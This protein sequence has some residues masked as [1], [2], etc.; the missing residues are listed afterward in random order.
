MVPKTSRV[1]VLITDEPQVDCD[2][3]QRCTDLDKLIVDIE[4]NGAIEPEEGIR[5]AARILVDQR[6]VF[7]DLKGTPVQIEQPKC[8]LYRLCFRMS[9]CA[10]SYHPASPDWPHKEDASEQAGCGTGLASRWWLE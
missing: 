8:R 9:A 4:T 2:I 10:T 3:L 7:A 6:V 1:A 5:Y